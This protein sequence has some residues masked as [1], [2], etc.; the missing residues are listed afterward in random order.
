MRPAARVAVS[1]ESKFA[2]NGGERLIK[3]I[4]AAHCFILADDKRR[5]NPNDL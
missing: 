5:I 1:V 3:Y 4:D 2:R